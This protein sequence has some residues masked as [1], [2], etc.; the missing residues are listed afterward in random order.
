[1]RCDFRYA[2]F[3]QTLIDEKELIANAPSQPNIRREF[4]M[5]AR[6]NAASIGDLRAIRQII[7]EEL[8]AE[9]QFHLEAWKGKDTWY[10][11]KYPKFSQK[12]FH[13][14]KSM[15]LTFDWHLWGHGEYPFKF[16]ISLVIMNLVFGLLV[17][18][19]G[20][21]IDATQP[22]ALITHQVWRAVVV[23]SFIFLDIPIPISEEVPEFL[24]F[25]IVVA[26]YVFLGLFTS[27]IFRLL[28]HR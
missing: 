4:M 16:I 12:F 3:S 1:M 20:I 23:A 11:E 10:K 22:L 6:I 14:L 2:Q 8:L 13:G 24:C 26:R 19:F 9:R 21:G 7:R 25:L 17:W 5:A 27:M 18:I 28:S 15:A